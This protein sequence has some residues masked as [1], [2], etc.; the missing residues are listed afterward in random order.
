MKKTIIIIVLAVLAIISGV[1]YWNYY[2]RF[3]DGYREGILYSFQRKGNVF[4]TYEGT[5]IQPGLRSARQGGLNT[6]EFYFSVSD[7]K[8]SD[9]LEKAI[10]KTVRLHYSQYRKTLPWR[11]EN[12]NL[13]NKDNGQFIVDRIEEVK[14]TSPEAASMY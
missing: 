10:G 14:E 2:N 4:K 5:M 13:D 3:S 8:V 11:G 9:S 1:F 7:Q 12:Y 6:N